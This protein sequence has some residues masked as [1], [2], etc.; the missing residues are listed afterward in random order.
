MA[1]RLN[2]MP[3]YIGAIEENRYEEMRGIA[4][5]RGYLRTYGKMLGVPEQSL[6]FALDAMV[7]PEA[8]SATDEPTDSA[9]SLWKKPG[10]GIALGVGAALLLVL[11]FGRGRTIPSPRPRWPCLLLPLYPG[12][13]C[14]NR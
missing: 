4:F 3:S 2:W 14:L 1:D 9:D 6:L 5:V 11:V 10:V 7:L 12:K 8:D 13:R